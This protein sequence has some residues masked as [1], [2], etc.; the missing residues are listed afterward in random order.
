MA[1]P[2]AVLDV[3]NGSDQRLATEGPAK[4]PNVI[5]GPL[6]R[7][8]LGEPSIRTGIHYLRL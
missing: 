5:A 6:H 8:V 7:V 1:V 2:T 4:T 3:P